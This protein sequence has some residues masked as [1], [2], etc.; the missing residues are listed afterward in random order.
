MSAHLKDDNY[1][2]GIENTPFADL[3][4]AAINTAAIIR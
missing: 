2:L 4:E 3:E 1:S